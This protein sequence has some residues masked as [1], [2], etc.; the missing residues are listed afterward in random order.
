MEKKKMVKTLKN[1]GELYGTME[2]NADITQRLMAI[3]E[4]SPNYL[5]KRLSNIH[6][7]VLHMIFHKIARMVS[8]DELYTDN[9][10]DVAGYATLLE[11]YQEDISRDAMLNHN[12]FTECY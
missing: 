4:T 3:I 7:E 5:D 6:L 8:G 11:E 1:R 10:H 9:M 12:T 2:D